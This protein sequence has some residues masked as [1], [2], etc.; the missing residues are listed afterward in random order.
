MSEQLP[1]WE[2]AEWTLESVHYQQAL[3]MASTEITHYR[4][5]AEPHLR[6]CR[7]IIAEQ[8]WKAFVMGYC[9]KLDD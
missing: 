9:I 5:V 8:N 4:A 1:L 6:V 2:K 3:D 7:A